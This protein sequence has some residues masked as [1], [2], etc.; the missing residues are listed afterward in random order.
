MAKWWMIGLVL[1][2]SAAYPL[3]LSAQ[4]PVPLASVTT[5]ILDL[6]RPNGAVQRVLLSV[7]ADARGMIVM[8]PG[9]AGD[10]GIGRDG[11][12]A[13]GDNFVVRTRSLW[14]ARGY[15][16]LIPDAL[17][18]DNMRGRRSSPGYARVIGDLVALAH[19]EGPGP[20]FLLGTSQGSIAAM[21]G[22]AHAVPG[23]VAGVVLTESVSVLG[24]SH[25]TVFDADP[26]RVTVPALVVANRDDACDVAPPA[27]APRIAAAMTHSPTVKVLTVSGGVTRSDKACGSLT[28]HG[29][30]GIEDQVVDAIARW[31]DAHSR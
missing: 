19:R 7:P 15:G 31:M 29:Y 20:V 24:G 16:V 6:P 22:A 1:A 5:R 11:A 3:P 25:E 17:G 10:V 2:G 9:G 14:N 23:S 27:D 28:P 26:A 18:G 8:L 12:T 21:N 4:A 13:H 30:Y